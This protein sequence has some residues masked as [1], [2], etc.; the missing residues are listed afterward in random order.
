MQFI[1]NSPPQYQTMVPAPPVTLAQISPL[2]PQSSLPPA[3]VTAPTAPVVPI[4]VAS[5]LPAVFNPKHHVQSIDDANKAA[6][7]MAM[8]KAMMDQQKA[9]PPQGPTMADLSNFMLFQGSTLCYRCRNPNT[10]MRTKFPRQRDSWGEPCAKQY[11]CINIFEA[12]LNC[13]CYFFCKL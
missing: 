4:G 8:Y 9:T 5:A 1:Q 13:S 2:P 3:Q 7:Q 12:L 10:N 11:L 6:L